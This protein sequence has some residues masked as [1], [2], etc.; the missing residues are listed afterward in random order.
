ML[1]IILWIWLPSAP[2][3]TIWV[4]SFLSGGKASANITAMHY[5]SRNLQNL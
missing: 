3:T 5:F 2:E 4:D 1:I